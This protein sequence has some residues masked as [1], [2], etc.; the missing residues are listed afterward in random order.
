MWNTTSRLFVHSDKNGTA[1]RDFCLDGIAVNLARETSAQTALLLICT[2]SHFQV[3]TEMF[4]FPRQ[5][6]FRA[7]KSNAVYQLM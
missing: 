6:L 1:S 3:S 2:S 7:A 5:L 4:K